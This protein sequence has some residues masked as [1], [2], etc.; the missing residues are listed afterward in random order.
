MLHVTCVTLLPREGAGDMIKTL[1]Y[2]GVRVSELVG[3]C[4][5]DVDFTRCQIRINKGKG[6]KDRVVLFPSAFKEALALHADAMNQGGHPP[7]RV[8][9][10]EALQRPGRPQDPRG[11]RGG[12]RAAPPCLPTQAPALPVHLAQEAGDRRRPHPALLGPRQATIP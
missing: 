5:D 9:V 6:D 1:L 8:V 7:V 12:R 2:T 10:E 4:L 3:I 11:L